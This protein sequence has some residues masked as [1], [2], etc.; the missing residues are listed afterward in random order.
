[1]SKEHVLDVIYPYGNRESITVREDGDRWRV[2][3]PKP[4]AHELVTGSLGEAASAVL[5]AYGHADPLDPFPCEVVPHGAPSRGELI[6]QRDDLAV[7]AQQREHVLDML[8]RLLA[9]DDPA[10]IEQAREIARGTE[11]AQMKGV[12]V[13]MPSG[14]MSHNHYAV[15]VMADA[16][17]QMLA[18]S[19]GEFWNYVTT[20]FVAPGVGGIEVTVQRK[21]GKT[22][23]AMRLKAERETGEARAALEAYIQA[24]DGPDASATRAR[25]EAT[26]RQANTA[27]AEE[28]AHL[29]NTIESMRKLM[30]AVSIDR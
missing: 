24:G 14:E 5:G 29:R 3:E 23:Q 11:R 22:P 8:T 20:D 7:A 15:A 18:K 6:A 21:S 16:F 10:A 26:L 2:S 4:H 30:L 12:A 17:V 19:D 27:R 25:I 13:E 1:M 28:M 9:S